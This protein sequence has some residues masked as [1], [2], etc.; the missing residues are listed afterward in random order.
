MNVHVPAVV[1]CLV[2]IGA[3]NFAPLL[4]RRW[5]GARY[6]WPLD[7][8]LTWRDGRPLLGHSKTWRGVI[9][10]V[11]ICVPVA[12]LLSLPWYSG[13]LAALAAMTGDCLSSFL[14]RRRGLAPSSQAL[15]LDQL[16]EAILPALVLRAWLPLGAPEILL[17]GGLFFVGELLASRVLFALGLRDRPY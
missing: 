6:A 14:K 7:G 4:A 9:A 2:L 3:A 1:D 15:G 13:M 16:P 10:A 5:L 12:M 8:G 11:V 17:V